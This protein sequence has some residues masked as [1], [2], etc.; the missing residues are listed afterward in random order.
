MALRKIPRLSRRLFISGNIGLRHSG[1]LARAT[2]FFVERL[3]ILVKPSQSKFR[4]CIK[5]H[6]AVELQGEPKRL[7]IGTQH[8][9][10]YNGRLVHIYRGV[11]AVRVIHG[12]SRPHE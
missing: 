3:N 4:D 11:I 5:T 1:I 6:F 8:V 10:N 7:Y 12:L 9:L 2:V